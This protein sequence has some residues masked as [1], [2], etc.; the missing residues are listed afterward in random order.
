MSEQ[1]KIYASRVK[2]Y[3][4]NVIDV[5]TEG[6]CKIDAIINLLVSRK[7]IGDII[8]TKEKEDEV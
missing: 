3:D 7:D 8:I 5:E 4:G 6:T 2:L 1:T